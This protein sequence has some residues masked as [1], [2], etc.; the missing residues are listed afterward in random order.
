MFLPQC[1]AFA[2]LSPVISTRFPPPPYSFLLAEALFCLQGFL[3]PFS[4]PPPFWSRGG[5]LTFFY[6]HSFT[7]RA[8]LPC[9]CEFDSCSLVHL[10][11]LK[12]RA[13][14]LF[15]S[16]TPARECAYWAL[17]SGD[18]HSFPPPFSAFA[19]RGHVLFF[20]ALSSL[21]LSAQCRQAGRFQAVRR[22]HTQLLLLAE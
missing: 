20:T 16:Q 13:Y 17:S 18:K 6:S 22:H 11:R 14:S 5:A 15:L 10:P 8:R 12:E 19:V 2:E 21:R 4:S 3:P 1:N 9:V 7:K